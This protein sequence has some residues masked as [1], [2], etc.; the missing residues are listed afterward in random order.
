MR[1]QIS[2]SLLAVIITAS[3]ILPSCGGKADAE[4][5]TAEDPAGSTDTAAD[6]ET[7]EPDK[8]DNIDLGDVGAVLQ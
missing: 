3:V 5:N 1:K 7:K 6:A 4:E 8:F 2:A